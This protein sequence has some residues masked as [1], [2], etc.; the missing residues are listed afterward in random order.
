MLEYVFL[1][2]GTSGGA[3]V[4]LSL[5]LLVYALVKAPGQ[6]WGSGRTIGELAGALALLAA[7]VINEQRSA[8]PLVPL[9]I[10]R[11]KGLAAADIT[12]LIALAGFLS[13]FFFLTLYMQSSATH[14]SRPAPPTSRSVPA[15]LSPP[16]SP[17]SSS[18]GSEPGP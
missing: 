10:F 5:S 9:S 6:G 4:V 12:Q 2:D 11:V 17:P 15:S 7:F 1:D 3:L 8:N 13:M 16:A 18:P 14:R